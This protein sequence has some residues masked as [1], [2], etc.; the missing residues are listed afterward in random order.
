MIIILSVLAT[1]FTI[2][3]LVSSIL[4]TPL[5]ALWLSP[6]TVLSLT[7]TRLVSVAKARARDVP[8]RAVLSGTKNRTP[9]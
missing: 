9:V 4:Y 3:S 7:Q 5:C 2:N 1:T 6:V 8:E